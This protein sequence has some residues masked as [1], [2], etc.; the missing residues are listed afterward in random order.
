MI[1]FGDYIKNISLVK[2]GTQVLIQAIGSQNKTQTK[3][4]N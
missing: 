1:I 4:I 3:A 2:F